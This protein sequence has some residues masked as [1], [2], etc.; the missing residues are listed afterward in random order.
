[1]RGTLVVAAMV[2][3]FPS[4]HTLVVTPALA[5]TLPATALATA[6]SPT[7]SPSQPVHGLKLSVY[8]RQ[9]EQAG[10][11]DWAIFELD[12]FSVP[13]VLHPERRSFARIDPQISF[14]GAKGAKFDAITNAACVWNGYI[15]FPKAGTYYLATASMRSSGVT[16]NSARVALNGMYGGFIPSEHFEYPPD[17]GARDPY[18]PEI[19]QY[20]LPITI[21][22]PRVFPIEVSL[23]RY[24]D[25]GEP[26][27]LTLY[28]MT[29]DSPKGPGGK[30]LLQLV[31]S[32]ALFPE[33]PDEFRDEMEMP[34][35]SSAHC[36]IR[37]DR[38][39]V[40]QGAPDAKV[41]VRLADSNGRGVAGKKVFIWQS[42]DYNKA[43]L[44]QAAE[45]TDQN[46]EVVAT[47]KP[48]YGVGNLQLHAF[49]M[50]DFVGVP[51]V[52]YTYNPSGALPQFFPWA[53]TPYFD[54]D[55]KV[56]PKPMVVGKPVTVSMPLTNRTGKRASVYVVVETTAPNIGAFV[57][58]PCG[59]SPA[60]VLAPGERANV[61]TTFTF[62][63]E[64]PHVCFRLT[65]WGK[66]VDERAGDRE[67]GALASS[68]PLAALL[69]LQAQQTPAQV[70]PE[71]HRP[72]ETQQR[73]VGEVIANWVT[74]QAKDLYKRG[75][76]WGPFNFDPRTGRVRVGGEF[77]EVKIGDKKV[78]GADVSFDIG[79]EASSDPH[80]ILDFNLNVRANSGD[81]TKTVVHA[82]GV[83][84][85]PRI[86]DQIT[87]GE[88]ATGPRFRQLD[89]VDYVGE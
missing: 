5:Q 27:R 68:D 80:K 22:R 65:L 76:S 78:G 69:A 50:T 40:V 60:Q 38:L 71:G 63:A 59:R 23:Y 66:T 58:N 39:Y 72:M 41:T 74:D 55:F 11:Y 30:S 86:G 47:L 89:G 7:T 33:L 45:P 82:S 21:S 19:G 18:R 62:A 25:V 54:E 9:R 42:S 15:R 36:T 79:P 37:C 61:D 12:S 43:T 10:H 52:C 75:T 49:D 26:P 2:L 57:W 20:S 88:K 53:S 1:M 70:D 6:G 24:E 34:P 28:W 32:E 4:V 16:I 87:P 35:V 48:T 77:L 29:P 3:L 67:R 84:P 73:N 83:V 14:G 64:S 13:Q 56:S 17:H 46:G 51:Q 8:P 31:P 81:Y 44:D 85:A